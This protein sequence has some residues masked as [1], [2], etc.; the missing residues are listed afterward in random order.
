MK[1]FEI[2]LKYVLFLA[3]VVFLSGVGVYSYF[4]SLQNKDLKEYHLAVV[5]P[6]DKESDAGKTFH[7]AAQLYIDQYNQK[8]KEAGFKVVLDIYNDQN[9]SELAKIKAKE[10]SENKNVI[11]VIGHN[12][13]SV[14]SIGGKIYKTSGIPAISPTATNVNVTKNNEWYFR[15]IFNDENQG[16]FLGYYAK[17]IMEKSH[18]IIIGED[19][20]YGSYLAEVFEKSAD[21]FGLQV[22]AKYS[23]RTKKETLDDDIKKIVGQLNVKNKKDLIFIA[24]HY[25]E[26]IKIIKALRDKKIDNVILTPDSFAHKNFTDGFSKYPKEIEKPGYYS[27]D[28]R[29]AVPILYDS[30]NAY[31][32]DFFQKYLEKYKIEPDWRAGFAFD[33]ALL[34]VNAIEKTGVY[35]KEISLEESR[36]AIKEYLKSMDSSVNSMEGVTGLNYFDK[37]GNSPKPITIGLYKN[38]IL[39]PAMTQ[40]KPISDEKDIPNIKEALKDELIVK[41]GDRYMH[42]TNIIYT[43]TKINSI[44]EIDMENLSY[45]MD[46][47]IWFRYGGNVDVR[48]IEFLNSVK[49]IQLRMPVEELLLNKQLYR[50]YKVSGRFNADFILPPGPHQHVLG[51]SFAHKSIP[52]DNIIFVADKIGG[53]TLRNNSTWEDRKML[54]PSS[55]WLI[56]KIWSFQDLYQREILGNTKYINQIQKN[57]TYS[58]FTTSIEVTRSKFDI[59]ELFLSNRLV[60]ILLFISL[61]MGG[62]FH[63]KIQF[64]NYIFKLRLLFKKNNA[65]QRT[66]PDRRQAGFSYM[67][68]GDSIY[69]KPVVKKKFKRRKDDPLLSESKCWWLTS[70]ALLLGF[71]STESICIDLSFGRVENSTLATV[72]LTFKILWWLIPAHIVSSAVKNFTWE[73]FEQKSRRKIPQFLKGFTTVLIYVLAAF[74]ITAFVFGQKLTSILG[75]SG[76]FVM[77]IGL[78]LQMNISNM[79]AGMVLSVEKSINVNDWIKVGDLSAGKVLEVNWRATV[80]QT[81][82]NVVLHIPNNNISESE[83]QNFTT[84]NNVI[85]Q[86][87]F[88]DIDP[89]VPF[90][91]VKSALLQA[92]SRVEGIVEGSGIVKFNQYTHWSARYIMLYNISDYGKKNAIK[93]PIWI[94]VLKTMREKNIKVASMKLDTERILDE[95]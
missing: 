58:Q 9:D 34:F 56:Q 45:T 80:I 88:I 86:W 27:N 51:L 29:V 67:D 93:G 15:T 66:T 74:G 28:I 1:N 3:I 59:K 95:C 26:G 42:K 50:R 78:A 16:H 18:V 21:Q 81:H 87:L 37:D 84:P 49:P 61:I 85:D 54:P 75:T 11:G 46:L 94:E 14:S 33:A 10:I 90:E 62:L 60:Y 89:K 30:A 40:L 69:E 43:G 7:R 70:L 71:F 2:K 92:L 31:A 72:I 12:Y 22:R 64:I 24:G 39:I 4:T 57:I 77:I 35:K 83:F 6:M 79:F 52:R 48:N 19:L 53:I 36:L 5:G 82:T 91:K 41:Y 76:I 44:K 13:S 23:Y 68:V 55:S 65:I 73:Y 47:D 20:T 25:Q 17:K 8:N 32:Q 38:K 63:P